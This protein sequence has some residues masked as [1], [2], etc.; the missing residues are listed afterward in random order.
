MTLLLKENRNRMKKRN[1]VIK[2]V[3]DRVIDKAMEKVE[4]SK[5]DYKDTAKAKDETIENPTKGNPSAQVLKDKNVTK[6]TAPTEQNKK[7]NEVPTKK[8]KIVKLKNGKTNFVYLKTM[9]AKIL[10]RTIHN[11]RNHLL[12]VKRRNKELAGN[13]KLTTTKSKNLMSKLEKANKDL[14]KVTKEKK[15][16]KTK[17]S[18]LKKS[19]SILETKSKNLKE[20]VEI[21]EKEV[22]NYKSQYKT[23]VRETTK[24]SQSLAIKKVHDTLDGMMKTLNQAKKDF[25]PTASEFTKPFSQRMPDIS[26]LEVTKPSRLPKRKKEV[27]VQRTKKQRLA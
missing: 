15:D 26:F 8:N 7:A 21:K 19:N 2:T 9:K 16:Y 3:I 20:E 10:N 17:V 5:N 24:V 23:F 25:N 1:K 14:R 27:S 11:L 6:I 22:D 12:V 18:E 13:L 4:E